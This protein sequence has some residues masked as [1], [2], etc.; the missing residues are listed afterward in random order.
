[1]KQLVC[2]GKKVDRNELALAA[3]KGQNWKNQAF[4]T[5]VIVE[6]QVSNK[7][8]CELEIPLS[9]CSSFFPRNP[10]WF[11]NFSSEK[12][13]KPCR[14]NLHEGFGKKTSPQSI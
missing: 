13:G 14:C 8:Q 4:P 10:L 1:M 2:R 6:R 5:F 11:E 3:L 7:N 12:S 9:F